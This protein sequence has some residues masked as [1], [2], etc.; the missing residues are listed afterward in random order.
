MIEVILIIMVI[1]AV[2][3]LIL[4]ISTHDYSYLRKSIMFVTLFAILN[5]IIFVITVANYPTFY[6]SL[7]AFLYELGLI[8]NVIAIAVIVIMYIVGIAFDRPCIY[9]SVAAVAIY[10]YPIFALLALGM[11]IFITMDII[12]NPRFVKSSTG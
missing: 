12:N 8:G 2:V 5:I 11:S 9:V 3:F 10:I 6:S 1:V 7:Y 4:S